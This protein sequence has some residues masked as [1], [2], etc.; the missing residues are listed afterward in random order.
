MDYFIAKIYYY[1]GLIYERLGKLNEVCGEFF[2]AY[3]AASNRLVDLSYS[4]EL[5]IEI[6][7][8]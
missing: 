8:E 5:F 6:L 7:F 4:F 1:K 3:R 2:E